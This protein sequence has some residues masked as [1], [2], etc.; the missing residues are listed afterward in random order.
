[1]CGFIQPSKP[2]HSRH[3][4]EL[5]VLHLKGH[6]GSEFSDAWS[7]GHLNQLRFML[8]QGN[9]DNEMR[10]VLTSLGTFVGTSSHQRIYEQPVLLELK[11]VI[12]TRL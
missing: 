3:E 10:A 8:E 7:P 9:V 5:A 11:T 1:M 4:H 2:G 12:R 6:L